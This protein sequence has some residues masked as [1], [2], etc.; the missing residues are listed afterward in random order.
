MSPNCMPFLLILFV[1][2]FF[3]EGQIYTFKTFSQDL[4]YSAY[5]TK[6]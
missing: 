1:L 2:I 6:D 5:E 4:I 3:L